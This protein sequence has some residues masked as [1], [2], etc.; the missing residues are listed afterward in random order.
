MLVDSSS[1]LMLPL[2]LLY[3]Y[4]ELI[5][6][7]LTTRIII[8]LQK[9]VRLIILRHSSILSSHDCSNCKQTSKALQVCQIS[10]S[11]CINNIN[12]GKRILI[13]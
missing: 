11:T 12:D 4:E 10:T 8:E 3:I 1:L 6:E 9:V 7:L 13:R 2:S 5:V